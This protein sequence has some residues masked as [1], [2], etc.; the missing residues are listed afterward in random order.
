MAETTVVTPANSPLAG[1]GAP[2]LRR[3]PAAQLAEAFASASAA[4]AADPQRAVAVR[5]VP[6]VT[7]LGLRAVPGSAGAAAIE[8]ALGVS[9]PTGHGSTTAG[10]GYTVLWIGP[11][12]FLAVG[13]DDSAAEDRGQAEASRVGAALG[14]VGA[15]TPGAVVDLSANRTTFELTGPSALPV[16]EKGVSFDLHPRHFAVGQAIATVLDHVPVLVWKTGEQAYRI[17]PRASF[18]DHV[19]RW[20]IDAMRE[21]AVREPSGLGVR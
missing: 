17:L 18:A 6:F 19:G 2:A 4:V 10:G 11:D 14:E 7:Q 9:L 12:E 1:P 15:R 13:D 20:L 16:L 8:S 3:S 21:F 5:E